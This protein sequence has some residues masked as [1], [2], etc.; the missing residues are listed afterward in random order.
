MV[1]LSIII[2]NWNVK[3]LLEKCLDSIAVNPPQCNYEV[4]VVDNASADGSVNM[5]QKKFSDVKLIASDKNLGFAGGNNLALKKA[6]GQYLL[7]L[8]PDTEVLPGALQTYLD[9]FKD[10][11]KAGAMGVKLVN[12][13]LSLQPSCKSFPS[14]RTLFWSTFFLDVL[15]PK[16]Q[17]FGE[18]EMTHWDHN[19]ERE[20]DQPMGA[21]LAVRREVVEKVGLMDEQFYMYFDEVDWCYRIKKAGYEIWFTPKA[22][23][24][25]HWGKSTAQA[26][27]NMNKHW[28][29]SLY[30]F[31]KKHAPLPAFIVWTLLVFLILMKIVFA[32]SIFFILAFMLIY[33]IRF[34]LGRI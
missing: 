29:R 22:S 12:F 20:V 14:W 32:I 15:F 26:R 1:E 33:I 21:A 30:R 5:I 11:P 13:D 6:Q 23:I 9:F 17:I 19:D 10:H 8:N 4:F 7:L 24:I 25:H 16:S 28:Y 3:D 2:V 31:L 27:L 34:V 18:Y